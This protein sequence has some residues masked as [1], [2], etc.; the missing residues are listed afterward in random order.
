MIPI[1]PKERTEVFN[2]VA[3][4][5]A[6]RL[7]A[8]SFDDKKWAELVNSRRDKILAN[9]TVEDFEGAVRELL[10]E[11]KISHVVFFHG[12]L[13]KIAPNYAIGATFQPCQVNGTTRWMFQD[14]HDGSPPASAEV[15]PG[16]L[17]LEIEG[18]PV[19]PPEMPAF[20]MG[21]FCEIAIEKLSGEQAAVRLGVPLPKSKWHPINRP[22]LVLWSKLAQGIGYLNAA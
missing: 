6:K 16:D 10:A 7:F 19:T 18:Q 17:L 21:G 12:S 22:R 14:V 20:R 13:Q 9:E 15:Q 11:L 8:P 3:D 2:R 5:T 4:L 1:G